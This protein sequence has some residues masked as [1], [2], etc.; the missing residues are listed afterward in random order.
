M[1]KFLVFL[2]V[3]F[4]FSSVPAT[5]QTKVKSKKSKSVSTAPRFGNTDGIT[6]AQMKNY[7]EFI[8]SDELE[9]RDTPSRGLDIA[10]MYIA[11]HLKKWGIKPAGDDGTYFQ[12]FPLRLNKIDVSNT[13]LN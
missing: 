8:A 10:A 12:K 2:L 11:G 9:G 3:L 7:L 4:V 13:R 6:A 5:A 1:K